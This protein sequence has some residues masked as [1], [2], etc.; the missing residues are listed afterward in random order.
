MPILSIQN[1]STVPEWNHD[2]VIRL[3]YDEDPVASAS[4][5]PQNIKEDRARLNAPLLIPANAKKRFQPYLVKKDNK[6]TAPPPLPKRPQPARLSKEAMAKL[7]AEFSASLPKSRILKGDVLRGLLLADDP[8]KSE[9]LSRVGIVF[10]RGD[11]G[12]YSCPE[13]ITP[14][15]VGQFAARL[16][17]LCVVQWAVIVA[18]NIFSLLH[19]EDSA[20]LGS[21]GLSVD[22]KSPKTPLFYRIQMEMKHFVAHPGEQETTAAAYLTRVLDLKLHPVHYKAVDSA[23]GCGLD[24]AREMIERGLK[25]G[26]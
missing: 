5:P 15:I 12:H 21:L 8:R 9:L 13:A 24:K 26:K 25:E 17:H 18:E 1:S 11:T 20:L 16:A 6:Q 19:P 3:E 22:R 7:K 14:Q 10:D 4:A 23:L 2:W